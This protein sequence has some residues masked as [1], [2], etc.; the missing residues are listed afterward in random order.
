MQAKQLMDSRRFCQLM[1]D[2]ALTWKKRA[3]TDEDKAWRLQA[4]LDHL[5]EQGGS[6]ASVAP[7]K[8]MTEALAGLVD[9]FKNDPPA[10]GFNPPSE[11][12]RFGALMKDLVP[13]LE[14]TPPNGKGERKALLP[15]DIDMTALS[16]W[17]DAHKEYPFFIDLD[18]TINIDPHSRNAW[19]VPFKGRAV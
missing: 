2:L 3:S 15:T 1:D 9:E 11:D 8:G 14:K 7:I 17:L 13:S 4:V 6:T 19:I 10:R 18:H 12:E 16:G 5:G